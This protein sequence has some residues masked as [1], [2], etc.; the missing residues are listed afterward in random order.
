MTK[1]VFKTDTFILTLLSLLIATASPVFAQ[2]NTTQQAPVNE[3]AT[4]TEDVI[5]SPFSVQL[6]SVLASGLM[7]VQ[8]SANAERFEGIAAF[9][10]KNEFTPIWIEN[11]LPT[12]KARNVVNILRNAAEHGLNPDDYNS[13]ALFQKLGARNADTLVDLETQLSRSVVAYAQHLNAGRL[14]PQAVNREIVVFPEV[15]ASGKILEKL[16]ATKHIQ[17][18][19]RLLAPHTPRYER[20]RTA[21]GNFKTLAQ[22]GGWTLIAEGEVLKPGMTNPRVTTL[23]ARMIEDGNLDKSQT[24]GEVY[25]DAV[26][27]A[28]KKFQERHGLEPDGVIGP[29]T[30]AQLNVPVADRIRTMELNLE[31]RRWMQNDYGRYYVFANLADQV[32]KLVRDEKTLHA[33][34]IQVGQPYHRTPVFSD[35]MDYVELNPFWNVPYSIATKEYLPKLKSNPGLLNSQ[36]IRVLK[37]G[38]IISTFSVP[39][40][41]YSRRHFP[42]RL[43]QDSGPRNALGRVKFMF[44]NKFNV[45]I[46]DTPSKSKFNKASRYFSHGCLRLK[47][48]LTMAEQILGAQGWSRKKIDGVVRSGK[49]TVVKLKEKIPVHITY[50]TSWVNKDGSVHFRRD[51]YGRDKILDLA[52]KKATAG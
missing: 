15:V 9:Y 51:I 36:N 14:D 5:L 19:L 18:Y 6:K 28:V 31:R 26:V 48:P 45:Y 1:S 27:A 22:N 49:R 37:G 23:R 35:V 12:Q 29:Q 33:E 21:L 2:D 47:D 10:N 17:A 11:E 46:H 44:P 30:I 38:K 8:G 42:V 52:M 39:W 7:A 50:L 40:T 20:L 43:R 25:D 24:A 4:S 3:P 13:E 32:I 41:S 16:S 34:L